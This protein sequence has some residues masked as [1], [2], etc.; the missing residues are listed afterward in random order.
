MNQDPWQAL[1]WVHRGEQDRPGLCPQRSYKLVGE[2]D[3]KPITS[4]HIDKQEM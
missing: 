4:N 3:I 2:A 1:G